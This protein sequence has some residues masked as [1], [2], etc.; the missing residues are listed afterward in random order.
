MAK[1]PAPQ[2]KRAQ[3]T[4]RPLRGIG[5][6]DT[7]VDESITSSAGQ[8]RQRA[9]RVAPEPPLSGVF[10][11]KEMLNALL[12]ESGDLFLVKDR[13]SVVLRCSASYGQLYGRPSEDLIGKTDFDVFPRE[14]AE[15]YRQEDIQVIETGRTVV[16]EHLLDTVWGKR[17]YEAKKV[18]WRD[19]AG[20]IIGLFSAERDIT[21][22]KAMQDSLLRHQ[23]GLEALYQI[24][25]RVTAQHEL[26]TV[27]Q[28]IARKAAELSSARMGGIYLLQP[29]QQ[30]LKL[31]VGHGLEHVF[32]N[33]ILRLGEGVAGRAVLSGTMFAVEDYA[34]WEG[35]APQFPT[36]SVQRVLAVPIRTAD[37]IIGTLNVGDK[38]QKGPFDAEDVRLLEL[39]AD[40]AGVAIESARLYDEVRRELA[41]RKLA[42]HALR[43]SKTLYSSLVENLPQCII[44]KNLQGQYTFVNQYFCAL[45]GRSAAETLGKTDFDLYPSELAQKYQRDDRQVFESGQTYCGEEEHR[46]PDGETIYVSVIKTPIHDSQG[47]IS[48]VQ[49]VFWD[50]TELSRA[51][52]EREEQRRML[53]TLLD[54]LPDVIIFKDRD[55][56]YRVCNAACAQF[57]GVPTGEL[58]GKSDHDFWSPAEVERFRAEE[59]EVIETEQ[60]VTAE[61][62][63]MTRYGKRIR[64][65]IKTPL[66]NELGEVIGVLC[67]QRD[68]T[69]RKQA[70]EALKENIRMTE[71][72]L[73]SM[74]FLAM[75]IRADTRE[76]VAVNEAV[77]KAGITVG[78]HCYSIWGERDEPCV[79][80]KAP[81]LWSS[82]EPQRLELEEHGTIWDAN[83]VLV[84]PDL[85]LHYLFDITEQKRME[86]E[87][88]RAQKL[89]S[90][91]VLAGGIAHDFNNLLTGILGNVSLAKL[92]AQ[93]AGHD[94]V[95]DLL[96]DAE[97]ASLRAKGLTN[98][99]LTF[100]T[101]G[102]PVKA[103][104]SITK[105]LRESAQ[106]ALRGSNVDCRFE[107][108]ADLWLVDADEGQLS[109]VVNNLLI[110]ARQAMP[111]GGIVNLSAENRDVGTDLP[112]LT[113]GRYVLI[114]VVD[115]GMGIPAEHLPRVF[116][117]YFTT[118]QTGSGLGLSTTHSI[119]RNHGGHIRV[120]SVVGR[121]TSFFI[122][123]PASQ[124]PVAVDAAEKTEFTYGQGRV[125]VMDDDE[126]V[127]NLA[128]RVLRGA[129]YQ[130]EL[131][132]DGAEAIAS[133]Q[134]AKRA[135][136]PFDVVL[137]DL[138][139][140]GG[141]GGEETV[142]RLR[143]FD[144]QVRAI[145]SSGYSTEATMS[146]Y[147]R[148]GFDGVV[149]KPYTVSELTR[150]VAAVLGQTVD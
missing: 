47:Q 111:Q 106:F 148:Y 147:T 114:S 102:A 40:Q 31:V 131:A 104:V 41:E 34:V 8:T 108:A 65:A 73:N 94:A 9:H 12:N 3:H 46:L 144:P 22:R 49:C 62:E 36:G 13:N 116:D 143:G 52:G 150:V 81:A 88:Q 54:A 57:L 126:A 125:L 129:G 92:E 115:Q 99:L 66:R 136:A 56:V 135:G 122:Y 105:L 18:P 76:V 113:P 118:K 28:M 24:S 5:Q 25:L 112:T 32:E 137:L 132:A 29:D 55:S 140:V 43:E 124:R 21:E 138:T 82:G 93:R 51:E 72:L 134:R 85:Y 44:R 130:V 86:A 110:N 142:R 61:H 14:E 58:V 149:P 67:V 68:I 98:Q 97:I 79:W 74:P 100:S 26:S 123:L 84:G 15:R 35:R 11:E 4:D 80:C 38:D 16:A 23:Q 77:R 90:V 70:E 128:A 75:L 64:E 101:G 60:T 127:R 119:V 139:V 2:S 146:D 78:T 59:V 83:W 45:E 17:W 50:I 19:T 30:T 10:G 120:E 63:V 107:I 69:E 96:T 42:E 53:R 145:V 133:Y 20:H 1:R 7:P 121:G 37:G 141:M 71:T 33:A 95:A 87:L 89:E 109:Q 6:Q 91:G 103:T 48:G 39:F 27:L 117:P